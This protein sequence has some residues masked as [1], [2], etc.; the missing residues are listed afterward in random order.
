MCTK[1][2]NNGKQDRKFDDDFY[3]IRFFTKELHQIYDQL[4]IKS[5]TFRMSRSLLFE[6]LH[7]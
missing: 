1:F 6:L 2:S 7:V 5:Y 3:Y 4:S